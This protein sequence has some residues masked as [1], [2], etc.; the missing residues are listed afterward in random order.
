MRRLSHR[1]GAVDVR[2]GNCGGTISWTCTKVAAIIHAG[3]LHQTVHCLL[4]AIP[5]QVEDLRSVIVKP[6]VGT[7]C[8]LIGFLVELGSDTS[9]AARRHGGGKLRFD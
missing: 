2:R 9:S 7:L 5:V 1:R 8:D 4:D 3:H 6:K